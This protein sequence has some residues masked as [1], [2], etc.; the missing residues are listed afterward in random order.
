VDHEEASRRLLDAAESLYYARG[1]QAVG[2]DEVRSAAGVSLTRLYQLFPS[3]QHLVAAYL[4]RRD[5]RWRAS[6]AHYVNEREHDADPRE[7]LLAV[8]NWLEDWFREPDFRGCAFINA[9]GELGT[10]S[11]LVVDAVREHKALFR[12][13][14]VEL[15]GDLTDAD[16]TAIADQ[17]LLL[18]EGAT[19]T[20]AIT[21]SPHAARAARA[22]A[23]ALLATTTASPTLNATEPP[24][25]H[26]AGA[27]QP[28]RLS[29][30]G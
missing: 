14:L 5:R 12:Q 11:D 30:A 19:T 23:A 1:I 15:A 9:F 18:A 2:I 13:Y 6:L 3:K 8:F 25:T 29:S 20:A 22:A 21:G 27:H 17:L 4:R 26:Q 10:G 28:G 16:P 24:T 7:R